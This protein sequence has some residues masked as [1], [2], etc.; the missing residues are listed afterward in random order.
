MASLA[1][2]PVSLD[3][4]SNIIRRLFK[5]LQDPSTDALEQFVKDETTSDDMEE[6]LSESNEAWWLNSRAASDL[7]RS[8][9]FFE[10]N[11]LPCF[12]E[13]LVCGESGGQKHTC[14]ATAYCVGSYC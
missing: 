5:L 13:F 12:L 9:S 6:V 8:V 14:V 4:I 3:D 11:H 7:P 1:G 10:V 2:S